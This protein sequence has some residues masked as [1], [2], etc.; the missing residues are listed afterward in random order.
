MFPFL[1]GS[2]PRVCHGLIR[3]AR[4][5][6]VLISTHNYRPVCVDF[7]TVSP[8]Q[9]LFRKSGACTCGQIASVVG[10]LPSELVS[11]YLRTVGYS[12][13]RV[14]NS[15]FAGSSDSMHPWLA[16]RGSGGVSF[17]AGSMPNGRKPDRLNS[18][19]GSAP[20][21]IPEPVPRHSAP[22]T[23]VCAHQDRR[24]HSSLLESSRP[25]GRAAGDAAVR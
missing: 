6:D 11:R 7:P 8:V 22:R 1:S 16:F 2:R 23:D 24:A 9:A 15:K 13:W 20:D 14:L 21:S 12:N 10:C 19:I 3:F 17:T 25:G 4:P 5:P 18:S